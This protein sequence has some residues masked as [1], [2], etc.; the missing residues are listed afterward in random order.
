MHHLDLIR[1]H[2]GGLTAA[3]VLGYITNRLGLSPFVG[4]LL[5]GTCVGPATP[6]F[7]A[8]A[9][10]A[11]QTAEVAMILLMFGVGLHFHLA[12]LLAVSKVAL[13]GTLG[14]ILISALLGTGL[15]LIVGWGACA[16]HHFWPGTQR[17]Q[18]CGS[19]TCAGRFP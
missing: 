1:T 3:L 16:F 12:D 11:E 10:P 8:N 17:G 7:V 5:A 4:Y 2:T 19:G 18:Y 15:G 9:K 13:P 6:G 14:Q